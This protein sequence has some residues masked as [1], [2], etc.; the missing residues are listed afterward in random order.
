MENKYIFLL[1]GQKGSGKSFIGTLFEKEF[2]IKFIRVE[3]WAKKIKKD[4]DVDN[5]A[6][7]KQ[8]FEEIEKGI[9][10]SLTDKDKIVFEST[11]LTEYF[12][13]ML[14]NLRR[15]FQ[16]ITIGVIADN[17]ICLERVKSRDQEIHINISDDQIL[18]INEKVRER[19]FETDF[20]LINENKSE[21][22][23]TTE[24]G[25]FIVQTIDE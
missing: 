13:K 18:R 23:L 9:R 8:V 17:T 3:D 2:G 25:N 6:Y 20:S 7:L 4:R 11:V 22:E 12:D 5:E 19:N 14:E 24:I 10:D 1:I 15:D 21:K 16:V